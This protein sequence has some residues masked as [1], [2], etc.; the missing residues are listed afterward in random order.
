[1]KPRQL[2]LLQTKSKQL[3]VR[4]IRPDD[5]GLFV[6]VVGSRSNTVLNRIVTIKFNDDDTIVARCTC[7]WAQHGG[8]ACSHVIAALSKLAARKQRA[9]RFWSTPEE[10]RRQ[11]HSTFELLGGRRDDHIWITSRGAA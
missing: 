9:L 5:N 11:K 2:K 4:V 6:V 10:A 1:M 7:A 3:D 8:M